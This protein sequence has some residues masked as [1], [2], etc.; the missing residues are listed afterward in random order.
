MFSNIFAIGIIRDTAQIKKFDRAMRRKKKSGI[1]RVFKVTVYNPGMKKLAR[2]LLY[3]GSMK[4]FKD[5]KYKYVI[6]K[7]H[8]II[9]ERF[10]Y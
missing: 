4:R 3:G 9:L 7:S 8:C 10:F 1:F 6:L 2:G 5:Y